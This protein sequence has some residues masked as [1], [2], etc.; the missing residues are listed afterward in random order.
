LY[1]NPS[2]SLAKVSCNILS[3]RLSL[4]KEIEL[5]LAQEALGLIATLGWSQVKGPRQT[6]VQE[7]ESDS[8]SVEA[9][10]QD[11]EGRQMTVLKKS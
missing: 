3:C 9:V 6:E 11:T 1:A 7:E 2:C 5:S 8:E 4:G 10:K